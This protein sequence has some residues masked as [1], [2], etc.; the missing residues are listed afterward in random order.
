MGQT[1]LAGALRRALAVGV[2]PLLELALR[3]VLGPAEDVHRG[4]GDPLRPAGRLR[5][6]R[7]DVARAAELEA[8]PLLLQLA[9]PP[10]LV[11]PDHLA[12]RF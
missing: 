1:Q 12:E 6:R 11:R 5:G 7:H 2:V 10:V 3:E 8:R 4:R 9:L